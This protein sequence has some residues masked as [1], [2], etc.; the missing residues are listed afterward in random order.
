LDDVALAL[1]ALAQ[2]SLEDERYRHAVRHP[3]V[4][5]LVPLPPLFRQGVTVAMQCLEQY[6]RQLGQEQALN[7]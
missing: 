2:L 6:A 1:Y 5:P 7:A 4:P 3:D